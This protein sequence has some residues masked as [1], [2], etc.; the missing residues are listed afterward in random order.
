[1]KRLLFYGSR[2]WTDRSAI[3]KAMDD[4]I[5]RYGRDNITI[6]H[7]GANGADKIA[8]EVARSRGVKVEVHPADWNRYG[9]R[10]GMVRNEEMVKSGVDAAFGFRSAGASPG[11]DNTDGLLKSARVQNTMVRA[12]AAPLAKATGAASSSAPPAQK[13]A[14]SLPPTTRYR[15]SKDDPLWGSIQRRDPAFAERVRTQGATMEELRPH[16][17]EF[18]KR[19]GKI[20]MVRKAEGVRSTLEEEYLRRVKE[21]NRQLETGE[22]P[23]KPPLS[24]GPRRVVGSEGGKPVVDPGAVDVVSVDPRTL[25]RAAQERAE[26]QELLRKNRVSRNR[27]APGPRASKGRQVEVGGKKYSVA[28]G[29]GEDV[30]VEPD[31][32]SK[33]YESGRAPVT[34]TPEMARGE[35]PTPRGRPLKVEEMRAAFH[36]GPNAPRAET[37]F[38]RHEALP[39]TLEDAVR[40]AAEMRASQ[41]HQARFPVRE[42]QGV[43]QDPEMF[44][45]KIEIDERMEGV[46]RGDPRGEMGYGP[47]K[48][49]QNRSGYAP[50]A[51]PAVSHRPTIRY[52]SARAPEKAY[53]AIGPSEMMRTGYDPA[54]GLSI[55][56]LLGEDPEFQDTDRL[57]TEKQQSHKWAAR[58]RALARARFFTDESQIPQRNPAYDEINALY[59]RYQVPQPPQRVAPAPSHIPYAPPPPPGPASEMLGET[60]GLRLA[61]TM[62]EE[63]ALMRLQSG[64]PRIRG[65]STTPQGEAYLDRLG[66]IVGRNEQLAR[67][68]NEA[69]SAVAQMADKA[70]AMRAAERAA[71][72]RAWAQRG[73]KPAALMLP[74][75]MLGGMMEE[76]DSSYAY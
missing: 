42:G 53:E 49:A 17:E 47:V 68:E 30:R 10:A 4:A 13:T 21:R 50:V 36:Y 11:T 48:E 3:E 35:V 27:K 51:R 16:V 70:R 8:G 24:Q 67:I 28:P 58:Q 26:G 46:P 73:G 75:M 38:G 19:G 63:E 62:S 33:T 74:L 2:T 14:S 60:A 37:V 12:K 52:E 15:I 25:E 71:K 6:I 54:E 40:L 1:M 23:P 31:F 66:R 44:R 9:K 39:V 20:Q 34:V 55:M 76:A 22:A 29:P 18:T 72:F 7:G 45:N 59:Q 41:E 57:L 69:A 43:G 5:T 56:D 65:G 64:S 32:P 61:P